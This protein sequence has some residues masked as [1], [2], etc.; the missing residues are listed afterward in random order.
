VLKQKSVNYELIIA[1]NASSDNTL[2]LLKTYGTSIN[3]ISNNNNLGF[4]AANNIASKEA[5]GK[6][7]YFLNP[8]AQLEDKYS[9]SNIIETFEL[10]PLWGL[11]GTLIDGK[12]RSESSY[13]GQKHLK[14]T[15]LNQ[16][17]GKLAWVMG[18][19]MA[20][21]RDLF[22]M[23][24]GFDEDFFLYSEETDLCLRIRK[25][26][27]E[28]GMIK[29]TNISHIG[30]VSESDT[31]TY[32][33]WMKKL[34]GLYLFY[35]KHYHKDDSFM[36]S[37]RDAR[38]ARLQLLIYKFIKPKEDKYHKYKAILDFQKQFTKPIR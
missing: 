21:E 12:E 24:N 15:K 13:P 18:A 6:F 7:L 38:K 2:D 1:D 33:V 34:K 10:H 22:Y 23:I 28:I 4:G 19:S 32:N 36:L 30:A 37:R 17:P 20:I 14:H 3:V 9:L 11:A 26:G 8:D 35:Q 16:L 25:Q 27:K 5:R 31:P 29:N